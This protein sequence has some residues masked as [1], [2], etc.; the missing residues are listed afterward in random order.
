MPHIVTHFKILGA[1][2]L[3]FAMQLSVSNVAQSDLHRYDQRRII[4]GFLY[5]EIGWTVCNVPGMSPM[6]PVTYLKQ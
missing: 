3:D 5:P 6:P 4:E 2:P 1:M